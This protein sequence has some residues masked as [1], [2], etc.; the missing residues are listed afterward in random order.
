MPA[1]EKARTTIDYRDLLNIKIDGDPWFMSDNVCRGSIKW[2][3]DKQ[4]HADSKCLQKTYEDVR[5]VK[6]ETLAII[7]IPLNI[8]FGPGQT[9]RVCRMGKQDLKCNSDEYALVKVIG[10]GSEFLQPLAEIN[11]RLK[12]PERPRDI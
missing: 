11:T 8:D 10:D 7:F 9:I 1:I 3:T 6:P 12:M 4:T 2:G 5:I